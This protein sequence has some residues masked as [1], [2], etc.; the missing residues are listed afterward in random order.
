MLPALIRVF[1]LAVVVLSCS[2]I[3]QAEE[4]VG[5]PL[6]LNA[7]P[8]FSGSWEK[9]YR[10]SDEWE[11]QIN[12]RIAEIR[13]QNEQ[14]SE[15]SSRGIQSSSG[16]SIIDLARFAELLSRHNDMQITHTKDEIRIHRD[17]EADLVCGLADAPVLSSSTRF[18]SEVC[19]WD[20]DQ[21]IFRIDLPNKIGIYYRFAIS[22]DGESLNL[23]TRVS[24]RNTLTFDLDQFFNY[25]DAPEN[26]R[27][28]CRQTLTRGK[29]C[30][31]LPVS[32]KQN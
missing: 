27:Y 24:S 15:G 1:L 5:L 28:L 26:D 25:Y 23:L 19:G 7:K 3:A 18:G 16:T 17:G 31:Q 30:S 11:K 22:D 6:D 13:R 14:R 10:R 29:V 20:R 9:D 4:I 8:N 32:T 21:L 2:I 12:L